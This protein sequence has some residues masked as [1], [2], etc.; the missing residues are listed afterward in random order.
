MTQCHLQQH[1]CHERSSHE[2]KS[3]R[4]NTARYHLYVEHGANEPT[5]TTETDSQT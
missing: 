3:E 4:E 2:V 1:G 5:Y